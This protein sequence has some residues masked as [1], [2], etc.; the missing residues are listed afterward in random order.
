VIVHLDVQL[1]DNA[2]AAE[3]LVDEPVIAI[4]DRPHGRAKAIFGEP[5]HLQET[6]LELLQFFLKV[7]DVLGGHVCQPKRPVT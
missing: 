4:D 7:S 5:A 1:V 3:H 2:I 6:R